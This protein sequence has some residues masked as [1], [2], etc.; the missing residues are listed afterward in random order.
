MTDE[1]DDLMEPALWHAARARPQTTDARP[2]VP[3][4]R[5]VSR[6]MCSAE[7]HLRPRLLACLLKPLGPLAMAGVAA[8]AFGRYLYSDG[9]DGARSTMEDIVRYSS[10][11]IFELA[12]FVEQV[13]P[14][15]LQAFARLL[16]DNPVGLAA[17]S[18][19]A[20]MLLMRQLDVSGAAQSRLDAR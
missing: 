20:V 16:A 17:F 13:N 9:L 8:G 4:A 6:L 1:F 14:E 18:A 12:R 10:D 19:S 2:R 11:Q 15:A 7:Q 3:A 5:L